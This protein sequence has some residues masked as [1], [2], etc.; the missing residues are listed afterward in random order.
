[1]RWDTYCADRH[2]KSHLRWLFSTTT[3]KTGLKALNKW[4]VGCGLYEVAC[5]DTIMGYWNC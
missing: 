5:A 4:A 1:M 2:R 3:A